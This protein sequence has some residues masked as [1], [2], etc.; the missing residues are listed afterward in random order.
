MLRVEGLEVGYGDLQVVWGVSFHVP[1]DSIVAILGPNGAGKTTTLLALMG[2]LPVKAGS[3]SFH[4]E[5]VIGLQTHQMVERGLVMIPEERAAFA[6]LTVEENL[7]LGSYTSRA[8]SSRADTLDEVYETFPRLAERKTQLAGT[9]SGGERQM[10]AIGKALMARPELLI[11]DEPSLGLAP[12]VVEQIF[13]VIREI[14]DRGVSVLM[15][16]Q[17][18]EMALESADYAYILEMGSIA[19]EGTGPDL[20]ADSR[21]QEA[22]LSL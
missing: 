20:E 3:A 18:L 21:V 19:T 16:E 9:L 17:H 14:R 22:Y 5:S 6:S 2:L 8:R 15:V 7:D 10:L 13:G 12:I 4:G 1:K 11:L